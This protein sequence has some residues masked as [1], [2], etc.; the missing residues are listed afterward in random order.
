[1]LNQGFEDCATVFASFK[2]L[3]ADLT[4]NEDQI[5]SELIDCQVTPSPPP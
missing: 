1:M 3:A 5:L 4:A 2:T